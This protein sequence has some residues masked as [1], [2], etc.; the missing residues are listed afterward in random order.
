MTNTNDRANFLNQYSTLF[1]Y[2]D[3]EQLN[4]ISDAVL[5]EFVLNY[6]DMNAIKD[7]FKW[8]PIAQIA[9]LF[10]ST[11]HQKRDNYFPQVSHF[12]D[13]YFRKNVPQYPFFKTS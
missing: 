3:H 13:L 6:G 4:Q 5:V 10:A 7:L 9:Q 1:W 2:L 8:M 11:R 12:F